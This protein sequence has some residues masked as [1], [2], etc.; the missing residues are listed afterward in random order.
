VELALAR[1]R[2]AHEKRQAIAKREHE[3]EMRRELGRRR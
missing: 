3:R 2:R 1:G